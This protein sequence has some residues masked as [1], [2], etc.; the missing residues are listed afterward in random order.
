L[1]S[2]GLL[3]PKKVITIRL[4]CDI[5]VILKRGLGMGGRRTSRQELVQL[6][7][8]TKEGLTTREVAG[9][10]GRSPAAIRNLRYK[11]HLVT[12]TED[13]V[14]VLRRETYD[15]INAKKALDSEIGKLEERKKSLGHDITDLEFKKQAA[16]M[17]R[18]VV[19]SL[20]FESDFRQKFM[21]LKHNNPDLFPL[22]SDDELAIAL[23]KV[24]KNWH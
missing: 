18:R 16:E 9:K 15:L 20:T 2:S 24:L 17:V 8:L 6:E 19:Y 13:E 23:T 22:L 14:K 7:A 10:L 4:L 11:K 3:V 1:V 5:Q 12:R 21:D